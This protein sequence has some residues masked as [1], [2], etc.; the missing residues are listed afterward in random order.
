MSRLVSAALLAAL[1]PVQALAAGGAIDGA[2]EKQ[3]TNVM[4]I[5]MFVVDRKSTRLNSSH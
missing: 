3:A 5:A 2:V 4:A 1:L